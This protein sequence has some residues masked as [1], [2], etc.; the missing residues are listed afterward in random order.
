MDT[1]PEKTRKEWRDLLTGQINV[2]LE[3]FVL[4]MKIDQTKR[5][6]QNSKIDIEEGANRIYD[7][8]VKYSLAVRKDMETIFNK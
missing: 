2:K 1:I 3:N 7:I 4:Q 8:C 5:A 6:I